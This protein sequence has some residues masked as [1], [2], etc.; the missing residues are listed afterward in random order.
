MKQR[1]KSKILAR[2]WRLIQASIYRKIDFVIVN[3]S[4]FQIWLSM[5]VVLNLNGLIEDTIYWVY[6]SLID[7]YQGRSIIPFKKI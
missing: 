2:I 7:V 6:D 3:I 4:A 5:V 1:K